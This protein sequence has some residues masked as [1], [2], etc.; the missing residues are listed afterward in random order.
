MIKQINDVWVSSRVS[1]AY[2]HFIVTK[3]GS[4]DVRVAFELASLEAEH[5]TN[6][7]DH[8]PGMVQDVD[9]RAELYLDPDAWRAYSAQRASGWVGECK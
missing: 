5:I 8:A 2:Y 9:S 6:R 4:N 3:Y 1:D 7:I